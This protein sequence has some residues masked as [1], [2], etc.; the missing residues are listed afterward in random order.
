MNPD[1]VPTHD[2]EASFALLKAAGVSNSK[3]VLLSTRY[4]AKAVDRT[5]AYA[6]AQRTARN[7]V[8]LAVSMLER[9][10]IPPAPKPPPPPRTSHP[11]SSTSLCDA[12]RRRRNRPELS[13]AAV[14][15]AYAALRAQNPLNKCASLCPVAHA[16]AFEFEL[17]STGWTREQQREALHRYA[18]PSGA[19]EVERMWVKTDKLVEERL[20][21]RRESGTLPP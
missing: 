3:A 9:G 8:A 18:S 13:D 11:S 21:K 6:R 14:L 10:D 16:I 2:S 5:L 7:P 17:R 15:W 4:D 19:A 20:R 12:L 1:P